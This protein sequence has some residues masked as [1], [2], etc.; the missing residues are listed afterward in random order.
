MFSGLNFTYDGIS[1]TT[2]GVKILDFD[3]IGKFST[4]ILSAS[5]SITKPMMS[6]RFFCVGSKTETPPQFEL[7]IISE[8]SLDDT[9][10]RAILS[11]LYNRGDFK[12]F[13]VN[14]PDLT[15]YY[16]KCIFSSVD[17]IYING[18]CYGF[19]LTGILDSPYQY[20]IPTTKTISVVSSGQMDSIVNNSDIPDGFVYPKITITKP[21]TSADTNVTITRF[22]S[23]EDTILAFTSAAETL[24]ID[25]AL[26]TIESNTRTY[27][28]SG[29]GGSWLRLVKGA[30]ALQLYAPSGTTITVE[31]PNYALVGF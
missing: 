19:S 12:I 8:T 29:F 27:P 14:Q 28:M 20:G 15:N 21:A 13:R 16:Y 25:C 6:P 23:D 17:A 5:V 24:V 10:R 22:E 7:T 4:N 9:K 26:K 31:C 2:H 3:G 1:S 18:K 11:W 30:N